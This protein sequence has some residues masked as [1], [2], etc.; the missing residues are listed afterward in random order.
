[1]DLEKAS[2]STGTVEELV[3]RDVAGGCVR[4]SG[5]HSRNL[6]RVK[7]G[8]ELKRALFQLMLTTHNQC[9]HTQTWLLL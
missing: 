6:V 1:M 7:R 8:I 9:A 5:S 2:E 3:D 4:S